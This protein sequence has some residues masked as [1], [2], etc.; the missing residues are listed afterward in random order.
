MIAASA[1][2]AA[3]EAE[4]RLAGKLLSLNAVSLERAVVFAP[5]D[6][7]EARA[8]VRLLDRGVAHGAGEGRYWLDQ[9]AMNAGFG[10]RRGLA[11]A[12]LVASALVLVAV[13]LVL[14]ARDGRETRW[15]VDP[16]SPRGI[17]LIHSGGRGVEWE[18][19]CRAAPADLM[20]VTTARPRRAT[21][22]ELRIDDQSAPLRVEAEDGGAGV[23]AFGAVTP[24]LLQALSDGG[25][26]RVRYGRK[27]R[28]RLGEVPPALGAAFTQGCARLQAEAAPA[29]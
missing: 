3:R 23:F 11:L 16:L 8:L 21:A 6:A 18:I 7:D 9:A 26:V 22:I 5:E 25:Q 10:G 4:E 29:P 24:A 27:Q 14:L 20:I 2:A 19:R 13:G 1:A 12:L 17:A 15:R 28:R